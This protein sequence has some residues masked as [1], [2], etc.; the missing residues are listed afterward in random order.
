[1]TWVDTSKEPPTDVPPKDLETIK[2]EY[3]LIEFSSK[4][5]EELIKTVRKTKSACAEFY[6]RVLLTCNRC[7]TSAGRRLEEL[8]KHEIFFKQL[9][10]RCNKDEHAIQVV[11]GLDEKVLKTE[12]AHAVV[13]SHLLEDQLRLIPVRVTS[14]KA[15]ATKHEITIIFLEPYGFESIASEANVWKKFMNDQIGSS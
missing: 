8:P 12:I 9:Q 13:S 3:E 15:Q 14:V 11:K 1:M 7:Q 10:E 4:T 5:T 2:L 6:G